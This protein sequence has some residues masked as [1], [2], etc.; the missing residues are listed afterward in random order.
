M[1]DLSTW[2]AGTY[3]GNPN[4]NVN[5]TFYTWTSTTTPR[6]RTMSG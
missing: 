1:T 4:Y 2:P 3:I 6:P 5:G